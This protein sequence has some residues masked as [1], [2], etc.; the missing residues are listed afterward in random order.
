[1][2]PTEILAESGGWPWAFWCSNIRFLRRSFWVKA[3]SIIWALHRELKSILHSFF[4]LFNRFVSIQIPFEH[5]FQG[6]PR[7]SKVKPRMKSLKMLGPGLKPAAPLTWNVIHIQTLRTQ[8]RRRRSHRSRHPSRRSHR[9]SPAVAVCCDGGGRRSDPVRRVS[10]VSR[11]KRKRSKETRLKQRRK[12]RLG[13]VW[14]PFLVV[15]VSRIGIC[16]ATVCKRAGHF[17][18][19]LVFQFNNHT[20][21]S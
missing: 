19:S 6:H 9:T 17:R 2:F 21:V 18:G 10:R 8:I 20:V 13:S 16:L 1:M 11:G 5:G 4:L 3:A 15:K 14:G 7:S 12:K